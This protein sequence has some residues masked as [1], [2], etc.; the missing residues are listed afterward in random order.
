MLSIAALNEK[1]A[2]LKSSPEVEAS[3]EN[4]PKFPLTFEIIM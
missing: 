3:A 2:V 4:C 1:L